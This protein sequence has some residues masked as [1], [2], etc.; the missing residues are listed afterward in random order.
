MLPSIGESETISETSMISA[1][2]PVNGEDA[3]DPTGRVHGRELRVR[4]VNRPLVH[5][6]DSKRDERNRTQR[7]P[8][9]FW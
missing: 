1:T 3:H 9:L 6:V 5:E 8:E 4:D 7:S 2:L